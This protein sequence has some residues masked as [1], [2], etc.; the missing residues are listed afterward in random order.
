[1]HLP[2]TLRRGF[3]ALL[4][5]PFPKNCI[6][7]NAT[8]ESS[9]LRYI[10]KKCLS[11]IDFSYLK[12]TNNESNLKC[13]S[14]TRLCPVAR[15]LIHTIKYHKGLFLYR[16]LKT[17]VS[18][19]AEAPELMELL[20]LSTLTPIPLHPRKMR[21]RGF[22]QSLIFAQILAELFSCQGVKLILER[23]QD[24]HSQVHLGKKDREKNVK[25]VF[26]LAPKVT[27]SRNSHYIIIDDVYTS[28][29]TTNNAA[30]A[31]LREG[32]SRV[33]ILTFARD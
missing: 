32:I 2:H 23:T 12:S 4:D 25:N 29:A 17:I 24:T 7:C 27:I 13:F 28:G 3:S 8:T 31:L 22:N 20:H 6:H 21:E 11:F 14:L 9:N 26:A 18:Y 15:T 33:S 30:H 19:F 16:D 1:M 5:I 10:C